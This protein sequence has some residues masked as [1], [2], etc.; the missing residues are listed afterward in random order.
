MKETKTRKLVCNITGK[1]LMAAKAYYSKRIEK[2]GSEETLLTT[3]VCKDAKLL[4]KKGYTVDQVQQTLKAEQYNC[5]LTE[6]NIKEIIG[7]TSLRIN[8]NVEEQ[9]SIIKTDPEVS[10]F[11][12]NIL[13]D[14]E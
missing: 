8:T 12:Q 2:A 3:Y 7:N 5:T 13:K 9:I 10:K 6:D 11:I 14:N 4:L 1:T